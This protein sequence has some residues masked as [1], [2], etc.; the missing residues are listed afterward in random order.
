MIGVGTLGTQIAV[1]AACY[2]YDVRVY[3]QDPGNYQRTLRRLRP[4]L[5]PTVPAEEW[6]KGA[7]KVI[8]S[9]DMQE[10]LGDA[11]LAIEAVYEDLE[12]KRKVFAQMD[13][14]TPE[15]TILATNSS[16]IVISKIEDATR[17]PGKCVNL[18]F[19]QPAGP[20][21]YPINIVDVC[22]GSE[23][24]VETIETCQQWVLSVGCIPLTVK[25]EVL[26]FC[27]NSVWR[28]VKQRCL[29]LWADGYVDF[30]DIDRGWMVFTRMPEGPFAL[31]DLVGLDVIYDIEMSYYNESGDLKDHP[32]Q[33]LKDKIDRKE[34][35]LKTGRG[36][37]VYPNP[38]YAR[39]DFLNASR[40][41]NASS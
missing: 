5:N 41:S 18:H 17:R 30:R 32:P 21:G 33:A 3:D 15:R 22:G 24:T 31:M 1:Q 27:F 28:A 36:F 26:G 25:K 8:Q 35:G 29:K 4:I 2:G 7:E 13:V 9:I 19:Y 23:T 34:L 20:H 39:S 37:Y 40:A 14:M 10:A 6:E 38:E 16:S 11:D 12:L